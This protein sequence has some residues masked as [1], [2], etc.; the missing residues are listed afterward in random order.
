[1]R[2]S[3]AYKLPQTTLT[4]LPTVAD[5]YAGTSTSRIPTTSCK[6]RRRTS[7]STDTV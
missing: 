1:M 5:V 6:N 3:E 2:L 7:R 4:Q